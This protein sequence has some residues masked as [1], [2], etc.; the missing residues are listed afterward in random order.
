MGFLSRPESIISS[1]AAKA[2]SDTA[3][4]HLLNRTFGHGNQQALL[5]ASNV[6]AGNKDRKGAPSRIERDLRQLVPF[7]HLSIV[8]I[9]AFF[10]LL[11]GG[12]G[13]FRKPPP[14]GRT[15][16]WRR[17]SDSACPSWRKANLSGKSDWTVRPSRWSW[18]TPARS[19]S[20]ECL[21]CPSTVPRFW[22]ASRRLTISFFAGYAGGR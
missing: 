6:R 2:D 21:P 20:S 15:Q 1:I 12:G 5:I 9:F 11:G 14:P 4:E 10:A 3:L 7:F 8:F 19:P 16:Q 22:I 18:R 13:R 17:R